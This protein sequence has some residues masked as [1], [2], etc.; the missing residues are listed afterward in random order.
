MSK[1]NRAQQIIADIKA[2]QKGKAY[3][4]KDRMMKLLWDMKGMMTVSSFEIV[5]IVRY[6]YDKLLEEFGGRNNLN[7]GNFQRNGETAMEFLK[8]R[9]DIDKVI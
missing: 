3:P 7:F 8:R 1:M 2:E 9:Y 5:P 6:H 4:R